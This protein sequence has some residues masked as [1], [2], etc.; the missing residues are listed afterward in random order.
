M[1]IFFAVVRFFFND[2][3]VKLIVVKTTRN[4]KVKWQVAVLCRF[5]PTLYS[6]FNEI[7]IRNKNLKFNNVTPNVINKKK[8]APETNMRKFKYLF[9][10]KI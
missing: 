8:R 6:C 1:E 3:D 9:E 5:S 2:D 4:K 7:Y 10:K